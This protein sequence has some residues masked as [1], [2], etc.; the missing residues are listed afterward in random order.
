MLGTMEVRRSPLALAVLC[1][2]EVGPLHP[3]GLQRLIRRWGKDQVIN[4]EQRASLYKTI[5]RLLAAGLIAVHTTERDQQFPQRT[6]YELTGEGRR[7][8]R[9][10]L[11]AM[12]AEPRNEY[13]EFPA[14][15][16]FLMLLGPDEAR[17]VLER[18]G[19][20]LRP[21]LEA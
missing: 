2:L 9:E 7:V 10:W 13:P 3:Y 4:V 1:L 20:A 18:R 5:Q 12:V 15:L 14:A 17:A 16:S 6:V 8:E 21:R 11:A 19:A